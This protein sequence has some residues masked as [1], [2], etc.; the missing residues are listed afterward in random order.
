[1]RMAMRAGMKP[2][3]ANQFVRNGIA[4]YRGSQP[5]VQGIGYAS[6]PKGYTLGVN[7]AISPEDREG[8]AARNQQNNLGQIYA[9]AA[10][11]P[12]TVGEGDMV[13]PGAGD[14][15]GSAGP[16]YGRDT[17]STA[18]AGLINRAAGGEQ[19]NDQQAAIAGADGSAGPNKQR[20]ALRGPNGDQRSGY[21]DP[22]AGTY[23]FATGE[24][25]P[26]GWQ[27]YNQPQPQ[28]SN[29]ELGFESSE[30]K[31]TRQEILNRRSATK[32][33]VA[34]V[35]E[36]SGRLQ[37][38]EDPAQIVGIVGSASGLLND[39]AAQAKA[40]MRLTGTEIEAP[41]DAAAYEGTFR[42]LGIENRQMQAAFLDL[43]YSIA[44][45]RESGRLT[46]ADISRALRTVGANAQDPV[47][48]SQVLQSARNRLVRNYQIYEGTAREMYGDRLNVDP[49]RPKGGQP[50]GGPAGA[51]PAPG[52]GQGGGGASG[53]PGTGGGNG[54]VPVIDLDGNRI[55]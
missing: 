16:I 5:I 29:E 3:E 48:M 11:S 20:I 9:E 33:A 25:V 52:G 6:D 41:G 36:I 12:L 1:M 50:Q 37:Q 17:A 53:Q 32:Q 10:A 22:G 43:A 49:W 26:E 2:D 45:S 30:L 34:T 4:A 13:V 46:E 44:Q 54:G 8:V 55:E 14:P 47:A 24:R 35:D 23:H 42:E 39:M 31:S 21:F 7:D 28:G 38:A 27:A 51:S 18:E 19:L 15:R 40:A